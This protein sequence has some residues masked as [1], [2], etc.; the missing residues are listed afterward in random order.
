[1]C[2]LSKYTHIYMY[3]CISLSRS[4]SISVAIIHSGAVSQF[5]PSLVSLIRSGRVS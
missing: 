3:I 2:I 1:M 5:S 4:K